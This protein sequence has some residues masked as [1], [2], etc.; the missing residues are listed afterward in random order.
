MQIL[1]IPGSIRAASLNRRLLEE[2]QRVAPDGIGVIIADIH[3]IP[4]YNSDHDPADE[5]GVATSVVR[6]RQQIRAANAVIIATPEYNHGIPGVLKNA[7]DWA[8]RPFGK[9]ALIGKPAAVIGGGGMTGGVRAQVQL[10][11]VLSGSG[12]LV[13]SRPEMLLR[14]GEVFKDGVLVDEK[15][16]ENLQKVLSS[17]ADWS[18]KVS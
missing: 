17:L 1:A 6:L 10:R 14:F 3:D 8:S 4:L 7:L 18:R 12:M 2:A 11:Q 15:V 16:L 9:S 13:M 5:V